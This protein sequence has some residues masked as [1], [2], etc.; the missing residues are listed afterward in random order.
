[1]LIFLLFRRGCLFM[2]VNLRGKEGGQKRKVPV[3]K[4]PFFFFFKEPAPVPFMHT[5]PSLHSCFYTSHMKI[6]PLAP[7]LLF[8][9]PT[10]L[11]FSLSDSS[12]VGGRGSA[13]ENIIIFSTSCLYFLQTTNPQPPPPMEPTDRKRDSIYSTLKRQLGVWCGVIM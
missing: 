9:P 13:S 11:L 6:L 3:S 5:L 1:M 10:S 2:C 4:V 7:A 8:L 12:V